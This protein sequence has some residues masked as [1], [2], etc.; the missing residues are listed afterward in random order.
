M[1]INRTK[2]MVLDFRRQKGDHNLLQMNRPP[3]A[4][5][6]GFKYL[7]VHHGGTYLECTH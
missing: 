7:G 6:S 5:V 3:L 4:R 2:E 1:N